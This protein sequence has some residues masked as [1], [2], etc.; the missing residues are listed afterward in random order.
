MN[1]NKPWWQYRFD[2]YKRAYFLLQEI[3]DRQRQEDLEQI[4]K[5]GMIQRFEFCME[6]AWKTIRDYMEHSGVVFAQVVPSVVI[7][8]AGAAKLIDETE[9]WLQALDDRNTISHTYDFKKFEQ[10]I[11]RVSSSY[12]NDCF[13]A[14]YETLSQTIADES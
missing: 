8:D 14:L 6:L 10:V 4:A 1:T 2:N 7:K 13:G 11:E 3:C 5:E 12:I 9:I